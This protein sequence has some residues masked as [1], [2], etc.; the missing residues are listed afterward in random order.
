MQWLLFSS[1]WITFKIC[2]FL[3]SNNYLLRLQEVSEVVNYFQNL[4]FCDLKQRQRT[5][6][7][8][9]G[10]C[11]LLSKFVSL[12]LPTT[13]YIKSSISLLLWITFKIC[14]FV[15]SNNCHP[16]REIVKKVVNYFQNLYLCDS[17]Q[18][19]YPLDTLVKC[20]EL[21]LKFVSLWFTTT[22]E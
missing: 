11:E 1:L 9:Y 2:I 7:S 12:W 8:Y 14:I 3:T 4:Y 18:L 22:Y 19:I 5:P 17:Q 21:L 20:C 6:I 16:W 10:G 15:T 13:V